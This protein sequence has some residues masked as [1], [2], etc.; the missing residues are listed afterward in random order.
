MTKFVPERAVKSTYSRKLT[1]QKI[2]LVHRVFRTPREE[3][4]RAQGWNKAYLKWCSQLVVYWEGAGR[5]AASAEDA[6]RKPDQGHI[7]PSILEYETKRAGP[8]E[9]RQTPI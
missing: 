4:T 5:G 7:S 9:Y 3:N 6:H 2:F 8:K 1:S